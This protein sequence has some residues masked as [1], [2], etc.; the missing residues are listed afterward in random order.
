MTEFTSRDYENVD[1]RE[2]QKLY[3]KFYYDEISTA[4]CITW[5]TEYFYRRMPDGKYRL[6][7]ID[8]WDNE[9]YVHNEY[10]TAKEFADDFK[11]GCNE[12]DTID[13][14]SL[15]KTVL[16]LCPEDIRKHEDE[17]KS[18]FYNRTAALLEHALKDGDR[19][20][21][22]ALLPDFSA[23]RERL[24]PSPHIPC[25]SEK[26]RIR[27]R[28][29]LREYYRSQEGY[30]EI[31][32]YCFSKTDGRSYRDSVGI[33]KDKIG[34]SYSCRVGGTHSEVLLEDTGKLR[35][36]YPELDFGS[37]RG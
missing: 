10:A 16:G 18:Y 25:I 11:A 30:E 36:M 35:K 8:S 34:F 28:K 17:L 13:D 5:C 6:V 1:F 37:E 14:D 31:R 33:H 27:R 22:K 15:F 3:T 21:V 19:D 29:M 23:M 9:L 20:L 32:P 7:E 4:P 2:E 12:D 26:E 24:Y